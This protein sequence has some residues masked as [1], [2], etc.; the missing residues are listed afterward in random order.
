MS[1]TFYEAIIDSAKK[2]GE[3]SNEP[4]HEIADLQQALQAC[5]DI[6]SDSQRKSLYDHLKEQEFFEVYPVQGAP[7]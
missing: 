2:H 1:D 7:L 4:E 5:M 3:N 6:M